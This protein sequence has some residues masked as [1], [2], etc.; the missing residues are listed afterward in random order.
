M[1]TY[2]AYQVVMIVFLSIVLNL[3]GHLIASSLTLPLWLDSLGTFLTAYALGPV[4]G[5]IVGVSGNLINSMFNPDFLVYALSSGFM[6]VIVG[7]LSSKGWM[8]T[9][10]KT[11]SLSVLVTLVC[12]FIS[13]V[14]NITF[15]DGKIGNEWG[16][17][18]AGLLEEVGIPRI[19][20]IFIG[21]FY[22]DFLD[23]VCTL[24]ILYMMIRAY[25]FSKT[26]LPSIFK[27]QTAKTTVCFLLLLISAPLSS[28]MFAKARDYNSYVRTLYNKENS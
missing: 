8:D 11:M 6:A 23:K 27:I 14:L 2:K 1:K 28:K 19:V 26:M 20:R 7:A 4:C 18:I 21:Q 9:L 13:V 3:I 12:V 22:V 5:V 16:N 24:C 17:E 10:L 15:Y 25:R